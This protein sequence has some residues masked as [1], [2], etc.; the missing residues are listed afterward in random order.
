LIAFVLADFLTLDNALGPSFD[1]QFLPETMDR[2][3]TVNDTGLKVE[4][5]TE[6]LDF[7]SNMA[8][9]GQDDI[10]VTEKNNGT[11]RRVINGTIQHDPL[12]DVNV[13]TRAERGML[14]IAVSDKKNASTNAN[15][16]Q[17]V[18][19][20][21]TKSVNDKDSNGTDTGEN[22]GGNY[23]FKYE[24]VNSKL[25]NAVLLLNLSNHTGFAHNGGALIFG[26]DNNLY[27]PIGDADGYSNSTASLPSNVFDNNLTTRWSNPGVGSWI[28]AD[29]GTSKNI[30]SVDIAWFK[31]NERQYNFVI[32]TST[33]GTTFVNKLS[34]KSSGST[35]NS[36]KYI[37]PSTNA[38][39]VKVTVNGNNVNNYVHMTELDIFGSSGSCT[40]NIPIRG[41]IANGYELGFPE[42]NTEAQNIIGGGPPDNTGGILTITID[43]RSYANILGN[44][45]HLN[46]YYAYGIRNS[47]GLDFDPLTGNLWDTENGADYGDEINLVNPGFNSGWKKVQGKAPQGFNYSELIS[48]NGNGKYRDP[49]LSWQETVGPT[50][51]KFLNSD[52]LGKKYMNDIFV[53]DIKYGRIY[54]FDLNDNRD[55]LILSNTLADKVANS[56]KES[57]QA[58]FGSGFNGITDMDVGPDG[59][60]YVLSFGNGAIYKILPK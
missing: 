30:C 44:S 1:K 55:G 14:G 2:L 18:Y 26:P 19:L 50:E 20:Y 11:V 8:F 33:D 45:E 42:H 10:L 27:V 29:L 25:T 39:Y 32:A 58:I 21:F 37:I 9:L 31:G 43:G 15:N 6:G 49:E 34:G 52:K 60:L 35:L 57:S 46:K 13:A 5:V 51:I 24:L 7:P 40:T 17:Y 16:P 23:L 3:P 38:R 36:E 28:R 53:T 41:V 56:D 59:Y 48:F 47:F 12:L 4:K 54:H 22:S